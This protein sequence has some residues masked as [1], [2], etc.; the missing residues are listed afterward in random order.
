MLVFRNVS[1]LFGTDVMKSDIISWYIWHVKEI[2][3]LLL[4]LVLYGNSLV[5]MG[6]K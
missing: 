4:I 6:P 1:I 3:T 5:D 2:H